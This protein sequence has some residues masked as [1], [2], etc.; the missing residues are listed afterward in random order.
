VRCRIICLKAK[1]AFTLY[2][3]DQRSCKLV[4]DKYAWN[5]SLRD[6]QSFLLSGLISF[7]HVHHIHTVT[8]TV[9]HC[10]WTKW[11]TLSNSSVYNVVNAT[12]SRNDSIEQIIVSSVIDNG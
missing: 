8:V 11:V 9:W 5:A 6:G 4:A 12:I 7:M 3:M 2:I 1:H 10:T